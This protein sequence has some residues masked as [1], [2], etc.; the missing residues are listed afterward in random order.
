MA[1]KTSSIPRGSMLE[2][3]RIKS[4]IEDIEAV[5]GPSEYQTITYPSDFTLEVLHTKFK[6]GEIKLPKFQRKF[7]WN[8]TQASRLIDSFMLGLPVPEIFLYSHPDTEY[9]IVVDGHQRLQSVFSFFDNR[10]FDTRGRSAEFR[11]KGLPDDRRWSNK[12]FDEFPE[13]DQ[14]KLK[15]CTLRSI[16]IKQLQPKGAASIYE[17][18]DR[19][20]T[21]GTNLTPQE[22]RNCVY[23]GELNDLLIN[24]NEHTSS[25]REI[26]GRSVPHKRQKDVE[27][28][29]RFFAL[30]NKG[31]EKTVEFLDKLKNL[32]RNR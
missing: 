25:W 4:E 8:L 28:V 29:L 11:L 22:V 18:F 2:F 10:W 12:T 20:N 3:E 24:V 23:A 16:T 6:N 27:L 9:D 7:M 5:G 13:A 1:E 30:L 15:R 14:R 26:L 32:G 19:L 17:I 21:G 31:N